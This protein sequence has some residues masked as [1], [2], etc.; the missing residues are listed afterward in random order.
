MCIDNWPTP[1]VCVDGYWFDRE[2][3]YC[4]PI[5]EVNCTLSTMAPTQPP[6]TTETTPF[7]LCQEARNGTYVANRMA[8]GEFFVSSSRPFVLCCKLKLFFKV[9]INEEPHPRR[10]Q[11]GLW[12]SFIQ[13]RCTDTYETQCD[14]YPIVCLGAEDD[15][16]FRSPASC[17]DFVTCYDGVPF[18]SRCWHN[19]FFDEVTGQCLPP[20]EV[21]CDLNIPTE[22]PRTPC[23]GA[24]DFGL[25]ASWDSC[26]EFFL[27]Y[28]DEIWDT[29]Q[30]P[31]GQIFNE[32]RQ[33]CGGEGEGFECWL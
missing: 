29:L 8:C 26:E 21:E 4:R 31:E 22:P 13:Q 23:D 28:A 33:V 14:L 9:C 7:T 12:F 19:M 15:A 18:P 3:Q 2:L 17:S 16:P 24:R 1:V 11:E 30:C 20:D 10:C 6:T 5:D 32:A 27:C 25:V